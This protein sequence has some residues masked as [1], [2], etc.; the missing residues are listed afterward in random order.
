MW[1]RWVS[2]TVP[3]CLSAC[4]AQAPELTGSVVLVMALVAL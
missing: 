4:G 3:G 2:A 1:L